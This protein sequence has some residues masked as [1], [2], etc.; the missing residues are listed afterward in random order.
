MA[1]TQEV[2]HAYRHLYRSLLKAVQY[3]NPARQI[4]LAQLRS[5]FRE[6][7]AVFDREGIKRTIW[8]FECAAR[9]RGI[10]HK[11][12]KNLLKVQQKRMTK[13]SWN[14]VLHFHNHGVGPDP[15]EKTKYLHYDM[16]VAMLNKT[17]GLCLR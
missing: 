8:F 10:E 13:N 12:L 9:E 14:L 1:A 17:M 15:H 16:T 5:G 6:Q 4:G 2:V 3:T 7:G 11:I